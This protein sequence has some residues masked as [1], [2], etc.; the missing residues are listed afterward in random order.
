MN[1]DFPT[2]TIKREIYCPYPSRHKLPKLKFTIDRVFTAQLR[3]ACRKMWGCKIFILPWWRLCKYL[4]CG[5]FLLSFI[6]KRRVPFYFWHDPQNTQPWFSRRECDQFF[7]FFKSPGPKVMQWFIV[8]WNI[9]LEQMISS[10]WHLQSVVLC[11][12]AKSIN[13]SLLKCCETESKV[14]HQRVPSSSHFH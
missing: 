1:C 13:S 8:S 5:G 4:L 3:A 10:M 9:I 7:I 12:P 11:W 2:A 14:A 6:M